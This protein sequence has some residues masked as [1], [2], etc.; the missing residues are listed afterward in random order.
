MCMSVR[1]CVFLCSARIFTHIYTSTM[2]RSFFLFSASSSLH[3]C[4]RLLSARARAHT[5]MYSCDCMNKRASEWVSVCWCACVSNDVS[6][7]NS[8]A[9]ERMYSTK[10]IQYHKYYCEKH[11]VCMFHCAVCSFFFIQFHLPVLLRVSQSLSA[12][13]MVLLFFFSFKTEHKTSQMRNEKNVGRAI[14]IFSAKFGKKL[15]KS[16]N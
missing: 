4:I 15:I 2:N 9:S 16:L 13:N 11:A 7:V 8:W 1:V 10:F 12:L 14:I 5:R 3:R 6:I